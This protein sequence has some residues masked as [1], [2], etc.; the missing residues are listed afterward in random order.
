MVSHMPIAYIIGPLNQFMHALQEIH[1]N[2]ALHVL[3]YLKY[4]LG[5]RLLYIYHDH[6]CVE[7]YSNFNYAWD[8]GD[9]K[10]HFLFLYL[11]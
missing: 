11:W 3:V 5:C 7:S 2:V 10:I 9:W 8:R 6:L 1:L 4:A